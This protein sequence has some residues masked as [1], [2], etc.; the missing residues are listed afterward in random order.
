MNNL[1]LVLLAAL[2]C[3]ASISR[4]QP[5]LTKL[6]TG[7]RLELD[8][9]SPSDRTELGRELSG[10]QPER[11]GND[12]LCTRWGCVGGAVKI[13]GGDW[14]SSPDGLEA[15]ESNVGL[16]AGLE[17]AGPVPVLA[18][19]GVGAQAYASYGTYHLDGRVN[20]FG[21]NSAGAQRQEFYSVGLFR[22]PDL[23]GPWSSRW[24]LGL[25]H[26]FS[27]NQ[28][29]SEF[30]L[31]YGMEQWRAKASYELTEAH[32]VG[33]WGAMHSGAATGRAFEG[34]TLYFRPVDQL[35]LFYKY[36]L[37]R[38]GSVNAYAGPGVGSH[39]P[40]ITLGGHP[41]NGLLWTLGGGF[42]LPVTDYIGVFAG[43]S[44][45]IPR[46][47][48]PGSISAHETTIY[49]GQAGVRFF[50]GGNGKVRDDTGRR[51][52][53]YLPAPDNGSFAAQS[54]FSL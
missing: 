34:V 32:E 39:F 13:G 24:G 22:R 3:S 14:R 23:S 2:L 42:D 48:G 33:L 25:V 46:V 16:F 44:Y 4:A 1:R 54:S 40:M 8:G 37:P 19:Y 35:N 26:D 41:Y 10:E 31:N 43:L 18:D 20:D 49:S 51:W 9:L 21:F 36:N 11:D 5:A 7:T 29:A 6:S 38:G 28:N 50:W 45:G 27:F 15:L 17:A 12:L 53:P 47:E 52:M 30:I